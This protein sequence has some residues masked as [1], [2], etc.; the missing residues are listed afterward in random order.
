MKPA[1]GI[2]HITAMASDP[3]QNIDFYH[4]V[5]GQRLVKKTVNFDDPSTYHFYY[6]DK[7][8]TPGTILT[9][10]PWRNMPRG[11]RGN[12]E[13]GA[14][15]YSIHET[16]VDYWRQRFDQH[17][18]VVTEQP[19]RFGQELFSIEDP[20][21]MV[22]EL[23]I[24]EEPA[25]F[26]PW[27]QGP[28]PAEHELRGFH[29]ATLWVA[30]AARTA[31]LLEEQLGYQF[32]AEDEN[33]I[34]Y[35]GASNDIGLYIDLLEQPNLGRGTMGAGSVHH[36]A[37]RTVDDSEQ[38]EYKTALHRAG[39]GVSPVMD[40]QYFHSI[41]FREPN[42]VLFEI[43][44][45]EPGFLYDE[46]VDELGHNLKLPTWLEAQRSQIEESVVPVILK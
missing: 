3:Q 27:N 38:A 13:V 2:H 11:V 4:N 17:G 15:A 41:Y 45:D 28:V 34:R 20:D 23:V 1:Q 5:L 19:N 12:G 40:R 32:V 24:N 8:G 44:T 18:L 37:F 26:E 39:Y 30:N 6:G 25:T 46:P 29:G 7:S 35:K 43:A 10:F 42:G 14:T 31:A 21:G 33:R 36:I 9:F 16:S 22:I